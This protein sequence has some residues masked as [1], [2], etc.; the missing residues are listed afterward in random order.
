MSIQSLMRRLPRVDIRQLGRQILTGCA[1]VAAVNLAFY[2]ML[3]QP[4]IKEYTRL[5]A[6][7]EPLRKVNDRRGVVEGHEAFLDGVKQAE[8]DLESL[9]NQVLSTRNERLVE[10]QAELARLCDRFGIPLESVSSSSDLLLDEGLDRFSMSV[11]LEGNYQNLRKFLQAVEESE[12]FLIVERV[13]LA[14]G[15][16]GGRGLSLSINLA[17]YF[18]APQDLMERKRALQRQR[19]G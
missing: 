12:K 3:T 14:R 8:Q 2:L 17:T 15:K 7:N 13:S 11:P 16:E 19:R 6:E 9:N 4:A 10:V 1:I 18:T 5:S